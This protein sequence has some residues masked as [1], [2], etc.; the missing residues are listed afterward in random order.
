MGPR[1]GRPVQP[2]LHQPLQFHADVSRGGERRLGQEAPPH[3]E[4]VVLVL[5]QSF[6]RSPS[7]TSVGERYRCGDRGSNGPSAIPDREGRIP[8]WVERVGRPTRDLGP[9][10]HQVAGEPLSG[11]RSTS[12]IPH[13]PDHRSMCAVGD[14]ADTRNRNQKEVIG[15]GQG[16]RAHG[17]RCSTPARRSQRSCSPLVRSGRT[18]HAAGRDREGD[19]VCASVGSCIRSAG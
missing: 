8:F 2:F 5:R 4:A 14:A 18:S 10:R 12:P 1:P 16:S 6:H 9:T 11:R 13:V 19:G 15:C 17:E 7:P 3:R